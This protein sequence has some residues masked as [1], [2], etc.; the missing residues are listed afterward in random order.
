MASIGQV[1]QRN[2]GFRGHLR[3]TASTAPAAPET[4]WKTNGGKR[5]GQPAR[6]AIPIGTRWMI[7][8]RPDRE[9]RTRE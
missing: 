6:A 9:T 4:P 3:R 2:K 5:P 1:L 8:A 7:L